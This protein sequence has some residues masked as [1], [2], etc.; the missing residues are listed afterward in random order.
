MTPEWISAIAS[1][2]TMLVIG[3]S[4]IAAL[5]QLRHLRSSNQIEL[6]ANW[7]EHIEAEHFQNAV[8]FVTNDLRVLLADESRLHD[9]SWTPLPAELRPL[10]MIANHFESVGSSV[11]RG[12]IEADVACDLW[13]YLVVRV[14]DGIL[15][16][17]TYMRYKT[18][19][20]GIWE[21]F[22]YLALLSKRWIEV[23]D[24]G[25]YP[26][27]EPRLP[28]DDSLIKALAREPANG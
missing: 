28:K 18:G 3:A 21:N 7:T 16:V 24:G 6:I 4:A 1:I 23:H 14:W 9:L 8:A 26:P 13:A 10:R 25:T 12:V 19:A 22:E 20:I 17:T 2:V 11:R 27:N 15:P 5:L